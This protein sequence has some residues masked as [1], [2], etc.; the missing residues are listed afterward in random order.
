MEMREL[1]QALSLN[2]VNTLCG[3]LGRKILRDFC[4]SLC[5]GCGNCL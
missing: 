1:Y 4:L 2:F 5:C 3:I